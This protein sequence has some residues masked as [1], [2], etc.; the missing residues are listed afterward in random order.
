MVASS[1]VA[2]TSCRSGRIRHKP[3]V[4]I[5][6]VQSE[7]AGTSAP[8]GQGRGVRRAQ[9]QRI[10]LGQQ[11]QHRRVLPGKA[12]AT[13]VPSARRCER[14]AQMVGAMVVGRAA[15]RRAWPRRPAAASPGRPDSRCERR[16]QEQHAARPARRP[17]CRAGR[18]S[19]RAPSR[20]KHQR[21]ARPHGDLPEIQLPGRARSARRCTRS[22]S[23]TLAPPVVTSRSMPHDGIGRRGDGAR[24][25]R[26]R[27]GAPSA[28]HR[29]SAPTRP[30]RAHW[31]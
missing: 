28:R 31:S 9:D 19:A 23:P 13:S 18:A 11:P 26:A 6:R 17:G 21:L 22:C 27:P 14:G 12:V 3:S 5:E 25:R 2:R 30:A 20:P 24:G 4:Q 7:S 10:G 8:A 29:R 1:A 16:Q 15:A